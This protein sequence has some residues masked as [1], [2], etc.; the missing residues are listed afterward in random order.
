VGR[1]PTTILP[2]VSLRVP[3]RNYL[4]ASSGPRPGTQ[5]FMS[6]SSLT[7]HGTPLLVRKSLSISLRLNGREPMRPKMAIWPPVSSTARSRSRPFDRASAG[8]GVFAHAISSGLGA[9]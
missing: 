8:D 1:F 6:T 4:P 7:F 5:A 9:G 3:A 2:M